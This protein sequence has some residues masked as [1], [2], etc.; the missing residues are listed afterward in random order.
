MQ[1]KQRLLTA[2]YHLRTAVLAAGR[3]SAMLALALWTTVAPAGALESDPDGRR[4]ELQLPD[5]EGRTVD[6]G[7]YRGRVV[8]VNFWASWCTPCVEEM[9]GILRLEEAMRDHPFAVIGVNVGEARLRVRT[10]THRLG[11]DFPVLLDRDQAA[12]RAWGAEVL[13]TSYVLDVDG[14]IRYIAQGPLDWDDAAIV[15]KLKALAAEKAAVHRA[16]R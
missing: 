13:P 5:L 1:R 11:L 14:R 2:N 7:Q 4:P 6:L 8:L 12:F 15:A 16:A 9:P 10:A 3:L